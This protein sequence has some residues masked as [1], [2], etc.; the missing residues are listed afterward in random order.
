MQTNTGQL[1]D[2]GAGAGVCKYRC[3]G[4]KQDVR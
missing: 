1:T 2:A 3:P 4:M